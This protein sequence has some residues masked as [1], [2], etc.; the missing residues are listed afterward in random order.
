MAF[1]PIPLSR[2]P[3]ASHHAILSPQRTNRPSMFM[4]RRPSNNNKN[5]N[6]N[7]RPPHQPMTIE[8]I[9]DS[10]NE[11]QRHYVETLYVT[12]VFSIF[13]VISMHGVRLCLLLRIP[14]FR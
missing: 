4:I 10:M 8:S 6:N 14:P 1:V 7:V 11:S 2:I 12:L 13:L 9:L 3:T 5:N